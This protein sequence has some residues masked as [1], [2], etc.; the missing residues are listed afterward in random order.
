M[1]V[2]FRGEDVSLR[3][4]VAVKVLRAELAADPASRERFLREARAVAALDHEH[5]ITVYHVGEQDGVPYMGMPWLKGL[6][7]ETLLR[8]GGRLS[9]PAV[10]HLG[11]QTALGL[12][13][14]HAGGLLHRDIKPANLW[15]ELPEGVSS[16]LEPVSDVAAA[17]RIKILDFG[18]AR[19]TGDDGPLTH[20]GAAVGTP[21]YMSP[22]QAA[23]TRVDARSDLYGLGV[24]LYRMC[25]GSL[26]SAGRSRQTRG[27]FFHRN[28][29][30]SAS[31]VNPDVPR[32]L[33]E[34]IARL[35]STD[36]ARRPASAAEVANLLAT[37][38]GLPLRAVGPE[39]VA[40]GIPGRAWYRTAITV[41]AL[42]ATVLLAF[43]LGR[44]AMPP[45]VDHRREPPPD[46][47]SPRGLPPLTGQDF[48]PDDALLQDV[49]ARIAKDK[50]RLPP[51]MTQLADRAKAFHRAAL[52]SYQAGD[53]ERAGELAI[54]VDD[55][56]RGLDRI[57]RA[58]LSNEADLPPP[59]LDGLPPRERLKG[60]RP[61]PPGPPPGEQPW[62][63]AYHELEIARDRLH[64][65]GEAVAT[66]PFLNAARGAYASA[67]KAYAA[68][69]YRKA[70]E[71]T[72]GAGILT[73]VGEHLW[74][75]RWDGDG[76]R[77]G[78]PRRPPEGPGRQKEPPPPPRDGPPERRV[79]PPLPP[80][81]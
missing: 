1:G 32:Q 12:A 38:E 60:R 13:A 16:I 6:S 49:A 21:A 36:P 47:N 42:M 29:S 9:I 52:Q 35:L 67:R 64:D 45:A 22:E 41:A 26:P 18:L 44:F 75:A 79:P 28:Q 63:I 71:L 70:T 23:G 7:L 57:V 78:G 20:S 24:V 72:V 40:R 76:A 17:G 37:L 31:E 46:I 25:T 48:R 11:R 77:P 55:T 8:R 61:P 81:E 56:A 4:S 19:S 66:D 34:L 33:A 39:R 51:A 54:A 58:T 53:R 2:V 59:E 69:E 80:D 3:R 68:G 65:A 73:H 62:Q 27:F 43:V 15:V 10:V 74:R 14:A 5:V 50:D 30:L